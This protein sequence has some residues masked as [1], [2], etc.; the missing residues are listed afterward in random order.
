MLTG[1]FHDDLGVWVAAAG[2]VPA[3][4]R[5]ALFLDRDGVIVEDPGYLR[6]PDEMVVIPGAADLIAAANRRG[7]PVIEVTNQAGIARGYFGW[8]EFLDV[9]KALAEELERGGAR[10]DGI[11]ACPYHPQGSAP[12]QHAAHPARKPA[13]GMLLA[14]A[15]LLNLDL[16]RSWL[17]GDKVD[18][19]LAASNAGL[20]GALQVLTGHGREHR[21]PAIARKPEGFE[22]RFGGSIRDAAP[23]LD[24]LARDNP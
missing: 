20:P 9:E 1:R 8:P 5:P 3:A 24:L 4:P 2:T 21:E 16:R 13:P 18:D 22:L 14:A 7:I 23:L 6:S 10:I 12:W 15:R 11:F 19:V 17:V